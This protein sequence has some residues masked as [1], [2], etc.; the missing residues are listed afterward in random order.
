MVLITENRN[1]KYLL[2]ISVYLVQGVA[3]LLIFT[4]LP[5]YLKNYKGLPDLAIGILAGVSLLPIILKPLVAVISDNYA[6]KK[7]GGKDPGAGN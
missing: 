3:T 7:L 6:I 2:Y 5:I 4:V 1:Y